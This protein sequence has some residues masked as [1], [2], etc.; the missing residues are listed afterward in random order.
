MFGE[1]VSVP[2]DF[3]TFKHV[4]ERAYLQLD[5]LT[6]A[7]VHYLPIYFRDAQKCAVLP[8][9]STHRF[10]ISDIAMHAF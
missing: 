6:I 5:V 8:K 9:K 3:D 4:R 1:L 10:Y 2:L 7:S